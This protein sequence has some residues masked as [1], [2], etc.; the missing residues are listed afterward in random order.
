MRSGAAVP[1]N[2][3]DQAHEIVAIMIEGDIPHEIAQINL[4]RA[5]TMWGSKAVVVIDDSTG[6]IQIRSLEAEKA[7][8]ANKRIEMFDASGA[9]RSMPLFPAWLTHPKRR[10]YAGVEFFPNPDGAAG[11]P[12]HLNLWRGFSLDPS[13]M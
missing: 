1:N 5:L 7:W 10:Q 4:T 13:E 6:P 12:N 8:Q 3:S 2:A 9:L 11:K